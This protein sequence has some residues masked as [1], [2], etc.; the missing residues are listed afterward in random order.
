MKSRLRSNELSCPSCVAKIEKSVG[1]VAG[2][3]SVTVHFNTGK[4]DV[5]HDDQVSAD[6]LVQA[7][8]RTGYDARPS[9][10]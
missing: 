10:M 5:E 3:E 6:A 4:I 8:K 7:V 2:V 9:T 1:A